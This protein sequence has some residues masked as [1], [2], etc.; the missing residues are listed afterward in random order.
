MN[1]PERGAP[2]DEIIIE[3]FR[4]SDQR[5]L[6]LVESKYGAYLH[7]LA[8]NVLRDKRDA[9]ECVNDALLAVWVAFPKEGAINLIAFLTRLTRRT[10]IDRYRRN[11]RKSAVTEAGT[12]PIDEL[13]EELHTPGAEDE[14]FSG[15][16]EKAI[17][18]FL[19]GIAKSRRRVFLMRYYS[20][21]TTA[22]IAS[23]TGVTVSAVV[24]SL[25]KTK[26]QLKAYFERNGITI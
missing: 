13:Y 10:A 1:D 11:T 9:E 18:A 20:S 3:Y 15:E 25:A 24:K 2:T 4:A 5:A 7:R 6:E 19:R 16:T 17:E 23:Q 26:K 21:M 8:F 12:L 22:E 14:Y